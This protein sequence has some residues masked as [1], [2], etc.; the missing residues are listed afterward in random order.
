MESGG[1]VVVVSTCVVVVT[2]TVVVVVAGCVV[3]EA[4]VVVVLA[5]VVVVGS[6][7]GVVV[8]GT[9]GAVVVVV[10]YQAV[11]AHVTTWC[12]WAGVEKAMRA[13]GTKNNAAARCMAHCGIRVTLRRGSPNARPLPTCQPEHPADQRE[14]ARQD[15]V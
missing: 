8:G 5:A 10:P 15:Q 13:N 3:V 4:I 9:H 7:F 12:A 2:G 11:W 14:Q 6:V 1:P